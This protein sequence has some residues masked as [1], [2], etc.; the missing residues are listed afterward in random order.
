MIVGI[1]KWPIEFA[2]EILFYPANLH[3][4]TLTENVPNPILFLRISPIFVFSIRNIFDSVPPFPPG[5]FP[6]TDNTHNKNE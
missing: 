3:E 5:P 2:E 6:N 4:S 1:K